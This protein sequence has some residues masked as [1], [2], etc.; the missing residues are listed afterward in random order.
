MKISALVTFYNQADYV[1]DALNGLISQKTDFEYEIL[2]GDDGSDDCTVS[3][4]KHWQAKYPDLISL[5]IMDRESGRKYN[6]IHRAS[7]NRL[8]LVS[9]ARGD[10]FLVLDGD[11]YYTDPNKFQLQADILD[12]LEN[13]DCIGCAHDFNNYYAEDGRVEAVIRN[14]RP[15]G[16]IEG[17]RYWATGHYF[18]AENILFR[19][20]FR[21]GHPSRC[22][23]LYFDDTTLVLFMLNYGDLYYLPRIMANCRQSQTS[24][25]Q[26]VDPLY[27]LVNRLLFYAAALEC[28]PK[29]KNATIREYFNVIRTARKKCSEFNAEEFDSFRR[30]AEEEGA[31]E[32][33]RW[34]NYSRLGWRARLGIQFEFCKNWLVKHLVQFRL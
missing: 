10:Y 15:E 8:N 13:R 29:F 27:K 34:L 5:Y 26:P 23:R 32:A 21:N 11:D 24:I 17:W 12:Q 20:I 30:Q 25:W 2:V 19:N 7:A 9:R 16:K 31:I 3:K 18:P 4:V 1:D 28:N 22:P 33:L 14:K 6:P